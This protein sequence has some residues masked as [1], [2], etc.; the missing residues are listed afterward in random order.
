M[1][2]RTKQMKN[3]ETKYIVHSNGEIFS[4]KRKKF[5][6]K[7]IYSGYYYVTLCDNKKF[8]IHKLIASHF[9]ENGH[10]T[11]LQL[12]HIDRNKLNN[13]ISNLRWC[14]RQE[15]NRNRSIHKNN[16]SGATGI[17]FV[18]TRNK[19]HS[20]IWNNSKKNHLGYFDKFIDA[21][22]KRVEAEKNLFKNFSTGLNKMLLQSI[23]ENHNKNII[24]NIS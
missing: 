1:D 17:S 24:I 13:N 11:G 18:K 19:F 20:Y 23:I 9:L 16:T 8:M 5:L 6:S 12:D 22:K 10:D 7:C 21:L 3:Y 4:I 14:T 2:I 15:N